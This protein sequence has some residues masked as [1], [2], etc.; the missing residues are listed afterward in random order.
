M[1]VFLPKG[2]DEIGDSIPKNWPFFF[3]IYVKFLG[4][5]IPS[6]WQLICFL[7]FSPGSLGV[8]ILLKM[9]IFQCHVSVVYVEVMYVL[10]G[11]FLRA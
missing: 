10:F 5:M 9:G 1:G 2:N 4:C 7:E 8:W 11:E 3:G 6:W